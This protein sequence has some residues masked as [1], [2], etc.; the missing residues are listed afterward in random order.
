MLCIGGWYADLKPASKEKDK[1]TEVKDAYVFFGEY[2]GSA[3]QYGIR[4]QCAEDLVITNDIRYVG[5][6]FN[7]QQ[8][9]GICN[10][11]GTM[12]I[13]YVLERNVDA[14]EQEIL[15]YSHDRVIM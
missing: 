12:P 4:R 10:V 11:N 7:T 15:K 3:Y 5:G 2:L 14:I 13:F 8:V 9:R 6:F 1:Q